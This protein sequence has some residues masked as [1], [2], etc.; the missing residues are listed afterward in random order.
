[1]GALPIFFCF[2]W[3][4]NPVALQTA[5]KHNKHLRLI[6]NDWKRDIAF[7]AEHLRLIM[8]IIKVAASWTDSPQ[9]IPKIFVNNDFRVLPVY[10]IKQLSGKILFPTAENKKIIVGVKII[11]A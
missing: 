2:V 7:L 11:I 1:M 9:T 4:A 6:R 8:G 3:I 5:D 10:G